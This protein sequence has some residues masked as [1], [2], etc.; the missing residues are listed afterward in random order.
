M[1]I[2]VMVFHLNAMS[3]V[4]ILPMERPQGYLLK[5]D[6]VARIPEAKRRW[7][8]LGLPAFEK[9]TCEILEMTK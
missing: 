7:V 9:A 1:T 3:G 6:C 8:V 4:P 2:W 5:A